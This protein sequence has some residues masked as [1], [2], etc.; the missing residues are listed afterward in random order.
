MMADVNRVP[1]SNR[2]LER[3]KGGDPRVCVAV[4]DGPVDRDHPCFKGADLTVLPVIGGPKA[5]TGG[6]M[7]AHGTHVA[8]ILFGQKDSPAPGLAYR[9][10]GLLVPVFSDSATKVSQLDLTR[11]I[12]AAVEAGANVI[13]IS[14]GQLVDDDEADEF[15]KR[16]VELCRERD[17]LIVA[18]A[19]N[20]RCPCHHLPA[21]MPSV[22]A[23]GAMDD[24]GQ[25]LDFSNWGP[26]YVGQGLLAP[27]QDIKGAVPGGGIVALTG[28]SFAAPVVSGVAALL[29]GLQ[30]EGGE[31]PSP[32]RVR[33]ALLAGAGPCRL[34]PGQEPGQCLAGRLDVTGAARH[35]SLS[36]KERDSMS[37]DHEEDAVVA[38][39]ACQGAANGAAAG[40]EEAV[41]ELAPSAGPPEPA[42]PL[43]RSAA[44]P[45][46]PAAYPSGPRL[47]TRNGRYPGVAPSGPAEGVVASQE[48][49][50]VYALGTLGYDFGTE[51]RR[52][53]FKQ[54]MPPHSIDQTLVPPN[55]Y[56]ARQMVDYLNANPSEAKAL[57][58]TLNLELTPIYAVEP[59]GPFG[60]HVYDVLRELM[61]GEAEAEHQDTY[62]QRVSIPGAL[63]GRTAR[64][65]SGQVVPVVEV[66]NVRGMYGWR[67]N[68]LIKR[69]I[70]AVGATADEAKARRMLEGFLNRIYYDLR[71]LGATSRDRA[72]NF[73]ATN[74]FQASVTFNTALG[75]GLEL[76]KIG[77]EKSP[78]CRP[79]SDCWDVKLRFF[80]PENN[81]RAKRVFRFTIDVSD[82]IPVTLGEVRTWTEA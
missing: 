24:D 18:A 77:V 44:P 55:P 41:P 38:S 67:T 22:L 48:A 29:L 35:L 80:D 30:L 57:I 82:T 1:G 63:T 47:A 16:A 69:T 51:A 8:S 79:D 31:K 58:W 68:A 61:S 50:L 53:T 11:G 10:R 62:I 81:Q 71:N 65:F 73:A 13:N 40:E 2:L 15:L 20:D 3:A 33:E 60:H 9:C 70:E 74:A 46:R 26:G 59:V 64:L 5:V 19:G 27:G 52:D 14:G 12:E 34:R 28:S 6:R 37:S 45:P 54:L 21:A 66:E 7:S 75:E 25:P 39:C 56:D 76:D 4:I 49:G 36:L 23:V 43:P 72:L 42:A 32:T 17:V 78:I